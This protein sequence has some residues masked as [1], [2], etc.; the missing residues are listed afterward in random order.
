MLDGFDAVQAAPIVHARRRT[1]DAWSKSLG[2]TA[3]GL[4]LTSQISDHSA[5]LD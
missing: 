4:P 1:R 5:R 2:M 3:R